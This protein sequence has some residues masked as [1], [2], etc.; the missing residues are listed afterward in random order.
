VI[1]AIVTVMILVVAGEV[2]W[3]RILGTEGPLL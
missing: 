3:R 2:A 1:G